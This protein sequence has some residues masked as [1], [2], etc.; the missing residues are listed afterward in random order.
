M[1][2]RVSNRKGAPSKNRAQDR[3]RRKLHN[4]RVRAEMAILEQQTLGM[5]IVPKDIGQKF[6]RLVKSVLP[7][8][9][10]TRARGRG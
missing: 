4:Q 5:E 8:G 2:K 1:S 9:G 7:I 6:A 10:R 3:R